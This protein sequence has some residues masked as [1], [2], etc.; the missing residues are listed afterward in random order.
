LSFDRRGQQEIEMRSKQTKLARTSEILA[1]LVVVLVLGG[2][3][4]GC[5]R[6]QGGVEI[7]KG[8]AALFAGTPDIALK[9]FQSA[10]ASN[11][12]YLLDFS[13]FPVGVW[14]YVGRSYYALGKLPEAQQALEKAVSVHK[15][16]NMAKL[17][18][19]LTL[20]RK[21]DRQRGLGEIRAGAAGLGKWLD[22]IHRYSREGHYWDPGGT[23]EK[24][25][26]RIVAVTE[27]RDINWNR[28]IISG[29]QLGKQFEEEIDAVNQQI[30]DRMTRGRT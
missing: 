1:G 11:P 7:R 4:S 26:R 5:G 2:S 17:Y 8:R 23:L 18:L 30:F 25:S 24:E 6:L 28:L 15:Q 19:G 3:F 20:F 13:I 9:D 12:N 16:D 14:T 22:D 21:G 27:G 29:E 10:A